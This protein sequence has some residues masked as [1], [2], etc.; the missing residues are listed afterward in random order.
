VL[1]TITVSVILDGLAPGTYNGTVTLTPQTGDPATIA[2]TLTV[3]APPPVLT[4][5]TP[6]LIPIGSGATTITFHGSGFTNQ[7]TILLAGTTWNQPVTFVDSET[8]QATLPKSDLIAQA[9]LPLSVQN[10]QSAPSNIVSLTIGQIGPQVAP[11]G[12][13]NAASFE[14]GP[15][16][17]GEI[18]SIFG[19][20]LVK[21]VTFDGT[22]ATMVFFS[23][24]QTDVTVPYAIAGQITTQ[25]VVG[26]LGISAATVTLNVALAAPGIFA[27]VPAGNNIVT[28]YATGCG[29]LTND[30]LPRCTLPV[31][32]TANGQLGQV[33]YAGIAPGL[34][35]G[36][37]QINFQLPDGVASG[38]VS[39]VLTVGNA[40]S[41]PFEVTLQ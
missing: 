36:V 13:V 23:P 30:A 35:Q 34:P 20:N 27:A 4:S 33:L 10:P 8:L 11:S 32:V 24:Q 6:S 21:N 37:D 41:K 3:L 28:L 25:L 12:V 16:A 15:V 7:S 40:A 26:Q 2:V 31:S 18:V 22:P 9:T 29:V 19:T 17:P 38:K 5:V 14:A 1:G 39:I